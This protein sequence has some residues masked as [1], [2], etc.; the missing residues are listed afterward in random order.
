MTTE[1]IALTFYNQGLRSYIE[2]DLCARC[3]RQDDKGCCGF[4]SPVFYL[5]DL[6]WLLLHDAALVAEIFAL[7]RLTVLDASV[8][9]N[10]LIDGDSYRC[11]FHRREGGCRLP[12]HLRESVCRHFVC[13]GINWQAEPELQD[14]VL[15]FERLT[16][17]EIALNARLAERMAERDLSLRDAGQRE[18]IF[19]LLPDMYAEETAAEPKFFRSVPAVRHHTLRR[20]LTFKDEWKL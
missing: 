6:A 7:E 4:Y 1:T 17:Y 19:A 12:Q 11:R 5:S 3:P 15:F 13:A 20:A 14:W 2:A 10:Q 9:L 18:E 8:T 16:E